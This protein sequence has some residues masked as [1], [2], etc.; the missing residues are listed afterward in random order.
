MAS[1]RVLIIQ[2]KNKL[3]RTWQSFL[4]HPL[5]RS[6]AAVVERKLANLPSAF[7]P[8]AP[9]IVIASD[10]L[11][12]AACRN[13][14][15]RRPRGWRKHGRWGYFYKGI[16]KVRKRGDFWSVEVGDYALVFVYGSM[17]VRARSYQEAM[18]LAEYFGRLSNYTRW[19]PLG[20]HGLRW[21]GAGP[22]G[23]LDC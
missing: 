9:G 8:W 17:P 14:T 1:V 5:N 2:R 23:I 16:L 10:Q 15:P 21:V 22:E 11:L 13:Q 6:I 20:S 18:N 19:L 4:Q 12:Q 7:V 3:A